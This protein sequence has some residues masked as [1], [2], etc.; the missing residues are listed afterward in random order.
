M[1]EIKF[2][3]KKLKK[4][5]WIAKLFA[6]RFKK[7]FWR[8]FW[9]QN[10]LW[11]CLKNFVC[12]KDN[13]SANF[14]CSTHEIIKSRKFFVHFVCGP[15]ESTN[16]KLCLDHEWISFKHSDSFHRKL[17]KKKTASR[18]K[19]DSKSISANL[20]QWAKWQFSLLKVCW[21]FS[22]VYKSNFQVMFSTCRW[23]NNKLLV[24]VGQNLL[25]HQKK[26]NLH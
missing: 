8:R 9:R 13:N 12:E 22:W 19:H 14:F 18:S 16:S 17:E 1:Y 10:L 3:E 21:N 25:T 20:T 6:N 15:K 2:T 4:V 7:A 11:M 5:A 26:S 24:P 23:A